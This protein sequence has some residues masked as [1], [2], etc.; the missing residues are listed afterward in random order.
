MLSWEPPTP[1]QQVRA[2]GQ[3]QERMVAETLQQTD[4]AEDL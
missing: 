1:S 2:C 3:E 4:R